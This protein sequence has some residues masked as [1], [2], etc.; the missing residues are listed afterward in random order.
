LFKLLARIF[1]IA[2]GVVLILDAFLPGKTEHV[3]VDRHSTSVT[4]DTTRPNSKETHYRLAFNAG[5]IGSCEV[6]YSL[7]SRMNDGDEI[8]VSASKLLNRCTNIRQGAQSLYSPGLPKFV[9]ALGGILLILMAF[10]I[11]GLD[12]RISF[13][14]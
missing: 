1:L 10:G 5:T 11:F 8:D 2:F 4:H 9:V 7:Y 14:L 3:A 13:Q 12:K 6:G